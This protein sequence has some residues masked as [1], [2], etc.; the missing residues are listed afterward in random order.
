[1][2]SVEYGFYFTSEVK[3]I[4]ISWVAKPRI[5]YTYFHF[6]NEIKAIFNGDV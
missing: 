4:Y 5:R 3:N 1:M 6:T 2:V